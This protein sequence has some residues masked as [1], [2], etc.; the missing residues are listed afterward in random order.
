MYVSACE[1]KEVFKN[2]SSGSEHNHSAWHFFLKNLQ[3]YTC[4]GI[5]A[6][7]KEVD[8]ETR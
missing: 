4:D 8:D 6:C 3:K 5:G 7:I 2:H 1:K